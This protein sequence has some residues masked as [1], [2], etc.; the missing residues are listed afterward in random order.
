MEGAWRSRPHLGV[1]LLAVTVVAVAHGRVEAVGPDYRGLLLPLDRFFDVG[2]AVALVVLAWAIGLSILRWVDFDP[3]SATERLLFAT[4]IGIGVEATSLLA[5]GA[6][7]L[8]RPWALVTLGVLLVWGARHAFGG[9]REEMHRITGELG[10]GLGQWGI[11]ALVLAGMVILLQSAMPPTDWD[12]LAYHLDVPRE[13]LN[14]GAVFLPGD[15]HHVAFVGLVHM[16]YVPLL[17]VG[18]ESAAAVLSGVTALL[19]ALT[20][21]AVGSRVFDEETG[22]MASVLVWGSPAIF[23]VAVTARVDVTVTWFLVLTHYALVVCLERREAGGWWWLAAVMMGLAV[24]TKFSALAYLVG[25]AP[26]IIWMLLRERDWSIRLALPA[27]GFGA[28]LLLVAAPW[29]LK[30]TWLLGAPLYPYLADLRLETWLADYLGTLAV[31]AS[32][33]ADVF[34]I[35]AL[36]REPF[37]IVAMFTDPASMSPE[38]ESDF[39]FANFV[40]LLLP[41]ALLG[42]RRK[43]AA[44][45]VPPLL[46]SAV[47][48][49]ADSWINLRYLIPLLVM[50][51]LLACYGVAKVGRCLFSKAKFRRVCYL[52]V[53]TICLLPVGFAIY[54]KVSQMHPYQHWLGLRSERAYLEDNSNPDVYVHARLRR[55]VNERLPADARIVMLFE[56]RGF[57]FDPHMLQ[58]NLSRSWPI[59]AT[60][61]PWRDC[62]APTGTTHVIVNYGALGSLVQRGLDVET[63]QWSA[64]GRFARSCLEREGHVGRVVLYRVTSQHL[65]GGSDATGKGA[66]VGSVDGPESR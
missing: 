60:G 55:W 18:A 39:Y 38:G 34:Q 6:V 63:V 23:L 64:F 44:L 16:L 49:V 17:A 8:L 50:G 48:L 31:P 65:A 11:A 28:V 66:K 51:T 46:Y 20:M 3:G 61:D 30:N 41:L 54:Y 25:L 62:L 33:D 2:C 5:L 21:Y 14:R 42:S 40:L 12:V 4:P 37:S 52:M 24:A 15:N 29:L 45:L 19:L 59:L 35:P 47:V 7:S 1:A 58:D 9:I 13:F 10:E 57:G 26:V 32:V 56:G 22:R 53:V 43:V 36:T 27:V